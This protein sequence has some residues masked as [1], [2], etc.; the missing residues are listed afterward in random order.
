M[1]DKEKTALFIGNRDCYQVK[2]ADIE[3]AIITAI[4]NGIESFLNGG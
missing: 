2:K 1:I 4:E 3:Q